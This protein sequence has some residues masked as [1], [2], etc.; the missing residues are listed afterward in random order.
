VLGEWH[1]APAETRPFA[2]VSL[3][4]TDDDPARF[5]NYVIAALGTVRPGIGERALAALPT[6]G[7]G[8][9]DVVLPTL[10]NELAALPM[11]VVLVL[12]DNTSSATS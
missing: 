6:A 1:A 3:D 5:W 4:E 12:D 8:L 11:P 10:I 7:P 9:V 2:W